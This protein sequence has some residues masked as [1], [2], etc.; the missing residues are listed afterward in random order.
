MTDANKLAMHPADYAQTV[1]AMLSV[2]HPWWGANDHHRLPTL[3]RLL[4]RG[5]QHDAR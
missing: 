1:S 2:R 4:M 3:F 5:L